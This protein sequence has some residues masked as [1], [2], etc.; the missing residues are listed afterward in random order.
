MT[1]RM[2]GR[3]KN[4]YRSPPNTGKYL[5]CTGL[6]DDNSYYTDHGDCPKCKRNVSA[7]TRYMDYYDVAMFTPGKRCA[8]GQRLRKRW[9]SKKTECKID[10]CHRHFTCAA[11]GTEWICHHKFIIGSFPPVED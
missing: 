3:P 10:G 7:D 8:P 1:Y 4:V 9:W 11:C 6:K 2:Y 5:E